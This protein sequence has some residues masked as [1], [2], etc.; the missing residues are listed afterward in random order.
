[1]CKFLVLDQL[2][3]A[4]GR[5]A[6]PLAEHDADRVTADLPHPPAGQ[7]P[8]VPGA[9]LLRSVALAELANCR[10]DPPAAPDEQ[11]RPSRIL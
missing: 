10:L 5:E 7:M 11:R 1:M 2:P 4:E 6:F 3:K 8:S 9:Y